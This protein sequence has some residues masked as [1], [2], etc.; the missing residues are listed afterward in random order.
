MEEGRAVGALYEVHNLP[1]IEDGWHFNSRLFT[2]TAGPKC[3]E[4]VVHEDCL[5]KSRVFARMC[6]S[7]FKEAHQRRIDLPEDDPVHIG[8]II[9][10]LYTGNIWPKRDRSNNSDADNNNKAGTMLVHLY[11]AADKYDLEGL[12]AVVV[13]KFPHIWDSDYVVDMDW[14]WLPIAEIIYSSIPS[15]DTIFSKKLRDW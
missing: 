2:V 7:N 14:D 15:D 12:K 6:E 3:R 1:H 4:W 10:Y 13:K 5:K 9:E 11:L 8:F